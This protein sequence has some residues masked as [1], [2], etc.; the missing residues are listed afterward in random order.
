MLLWE[1]AGKACGAASSLCGCH[2]TVSQ[3]H[4]GHY[5][6]RKQ[7]GLLHVVQ[8][9]GQPDD[10]LW[11][12]ILL[13]EAC[14]R[15]GSMSLLTSPRM[16]NVARMCFPPAHSPAAAKLHGEP[17]MWLQLGPTVVLRC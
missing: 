14:M 11:P 9:H 16:Q 15:S 4:D 2:E 3:Q 12:C 1:S 8:M 6:S 7:A 5:F 17:A 13:L 10:C